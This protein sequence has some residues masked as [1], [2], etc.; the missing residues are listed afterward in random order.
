MLD[1]FRWGVW[2]SARRCEASARELDVLTA[3]LWEAEWGAGD[4]DLPGGS[5]W[6]EAFGALAEATSA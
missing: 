2:C 5:T 4:L 3:T 1:R 6:Q